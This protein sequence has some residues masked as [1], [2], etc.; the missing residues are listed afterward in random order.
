MKKIFATLLAIFFISM[1]WAQS[2]GKM[3]YQAV[4]RDATDHLVVNHTVGM[5]ISIL[6]G[7]ATGFPVYSEVLT[8][9]TNVNGLVSVEIGGASGFYEINWE[10]GPYFLKTETDPTGGASYT[11]TGTSQLLSVPFALHA[12]TAESAT[13]VVNESDPVFATSLANTISQSD[14]NNWGAA[15]FWGNHASAGYLKSFTENDPMF[16][17]S[18]ASGITTTNLANWTAAYG[19]G[20]HATQGY[21]KSFTENDPI[22]AASPASTISNTNINNWNVGFSWGNH[23][24][25]GYL[26]SYTETDPVFGASPASGITPTNLANWTTA[27]GWGDHSTEGYLK[28]YTET[29]PVFGAW[30]KSTGISITASQVTDFQSGVSANT[31]VAANTLKNSYPTADAAKLAGIEAGAEV[32]VNAD[33]TA[34]TGDAEILN[35]PATVAGFGITDA[36]TTDS[37][38]NSITNQNISDWSTAYGWGDH[39]TAGYLQNIAIA[40][41]GDLMTFDGTNWVSKKLV[42]VPTGGNIPVS[43]IQ[44]YLTVNYCIAIY[45]IFPARSTTEPFIGG[46]EINAFNFAPRGFATCDGQIMS[47][48]SNTALFSL[49]GTMYGGDGRVTF[50][51]PDLRGRV[52]IHQ[53]YGPGLSSYSIGQAG[54]SETIQLT[55][56]N[57]PAHTHALIYQ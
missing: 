51:L 15:Y 30:D 23:A 41:A 50:A 39:A 29:D 4:I 53:G 6:Q 57:L 7:S 3:S 43:N 18:P 12:K 17:A 36:M 55:I 31:D 19:W 1:T 24:A 49:L 13:Y 47:I 42:M 21:L 8:P 45:G 2:P 52:A 14:I 26:K 11:I 5:R 10:N 54:G 27:F 34:T 33:W 22:F 16:G 44:P 37:P 20:N 40:E 46:I 35:K 28:S 56:Q 48:S 32:N 25:A 9:S 38:A